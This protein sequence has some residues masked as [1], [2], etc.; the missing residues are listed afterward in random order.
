M[1]QE[2]KTRVS[3]RLS[4]FIAISSAMNQLKLETRTCS[5]WQTPVTSA[6]KTCNWCKM[7]ENGQPVP[8]PGKDA[9]GAKCGKTGN[10]CQ[11]WENMLLVL[12]AGKQ[13]TGTKRGKTR[14]G[15]QARE[16]MQ[17]VPSV[18]KQT[19]SEKHRKTCN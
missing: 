14:N 4:S 6:A 19:T 11:A 10:R 1:F 5:R 17:L 12:G 2:K 13:A 16:N 18:D 15:C 7:R 9:T 3:M 8:R